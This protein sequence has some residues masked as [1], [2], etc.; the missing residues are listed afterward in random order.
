MTTD[1]GGGVCRD[2]RAGGEGYICARCFYGSPN[3]TTAEEMDTDRALAAKDARIVELERGWADL[4][5]IDWFCGHFDPWHQIGT[6]SRKKGH[7][8]KHHSGILGA[9]VLDLDEAQAALEAEKA[10]RAKAEAAL[11]AMPQAEG[12]LADIFCESFHG[13]A[14]TC[15]HDAIRARGGG[16]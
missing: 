3:H 1:T 7:G 14:C 6:C 13:R 5:P 9:L 8:G 2:C 11:A 16:A 10:A 4:R 15:G 12:H